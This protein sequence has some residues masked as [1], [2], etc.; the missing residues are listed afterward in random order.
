MHLAE[1][2]IKT[3]LGEIVSL[4]TEVSHPSQEREDSKEAL[5][6][7]NK[8]SPVGTFCENLATL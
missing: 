5:P 1:K 4:L 2:K 7:G 8:L 3:V 6:E